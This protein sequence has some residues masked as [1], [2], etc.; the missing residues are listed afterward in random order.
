MNSAWNDKRI[1]TEV[2]KM[3][4]ETKEMLEEVREEKRIV[5]EMTQNM[6]EKERFILRLFIESGA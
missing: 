1:E 2:E 5:A 4:R 3:N 6:I